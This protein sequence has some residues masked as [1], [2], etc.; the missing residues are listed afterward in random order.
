MKKPIFLDVSTETRYFYMVTEEKKYKKVKGRRIFV[1]TLPDM[2]REEA[3]RLAIVAAETR[4]DAAFMTFIYETS[5]V[6][7]TDKFLV[8]ES[9]LE[10]DDLFPAMAAEVVRRLFEET[11]CSFY[12]LHE[13][14]EEIR[15]RT[16][17]EC[18]RQPWRHGMS[19]HKEIYE[20]EF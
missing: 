3:I 18:G 2:P 1:T 19:V 4:E 15:L 13:E 9:H 5:G 11:G 17:R 6:A 8:Y 10:W 20:K 16:V 14:I 7:F 12:D